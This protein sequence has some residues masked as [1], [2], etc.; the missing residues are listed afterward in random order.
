[1][2]GYGLE[3]QVVLTTPLLEGLDGV[4]KMSKSM[5]NYVGINEEPGEMF[6]KLMSISDELMWKYYL[7]LTDS[8][9][10][11]IAALEAAVASGANH[12][13]TVKQDLAERIVRDFHPGDA[14]ARARD[15]FER[16]FSKGE[17]AAGDVEDREVAVGPGGA[18]LVKVL[19]ECGLAASAS[20]AARK[21][22]QGGVKI[23]GEKVSDPRQRVSHGAA[24]FLLQAGRRAVRVILRDV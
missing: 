9:E 5:Q 6:G 12:P 4:E 7:L 15:A 21:I 8:S 19:A 24:P 22:Q 23:D 1:M 2:P 11:E 13:K 17:I 18:A 3:P 10:A 16:R 20:E 14:A